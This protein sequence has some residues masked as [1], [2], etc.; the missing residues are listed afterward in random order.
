MSSATIE[1]AADQRHPTRRSSVESLRLPVLMTLPTLV[2]VFVVIGIPL[3]YSLA[4][5]LHRINM[6]TQ[7]WIF[8]GLQN[9]LEI[10]PQPDFLYAM[11]RT[12]YFAVVTVSGGLALG[13]AMALV[14]NQR[15]WGRGVLRSFVLIPWAMSPVAVGILWGW[16]LNGNYGTFNGIL[17]DLGL[18]EKPIAWLA[19]GW[20]ALN[21]VAL[22][23]IWNQA[24]LASL[25]ILAGLQSM[26]ENLHRAARID[27]AG[28]L[29]RFFRITLPWLRPMLLLVL[30]L[31]TINSIMAFDL[32]WTITK[33]GPGSATTVFSWMGYAYAFQ[34]F[35]FGEGAAI[36]YVLTILCLGLAWLYLRLFFPRTRRPPAGS[37]VEAKPRGLGHE[38]V[39]RVESR[40]QAARARLTGRVLGAGWPG[41]RLRRLLFR[42]GLGTGV[43]L[44]FAW[45]AG[46]FLWLVIMSLSPSVDL[47]RTP[48]TVIPE[49]LT[50]ENFRYV[51][52]PGGAVDGQ[53]SVQATRVPL[54]IWNSFVVASFVTAINV[55]IGSLAGY[56]YARHGRGKFMTGSLWALMMTRM[57]PSLALILP[58]F[59]IFRMADL[60]DTRT[61]L[62]IAYCS[63]ILPLSTWIMKGYFE[64]LPPNLERAALVDG[65]TR[66]EAIIKIIL[67]VAKPGLVAAGIF[68]FLVSWNEFIFALILTSTPQ[69]Q[70]I[71][72]II[73]GFL[74]QLRF[75]DYGPMFAASVLAIL[76]PVLLALVFQRHLVSGMLSGSLKG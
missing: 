26:P 34:F 3:V 66:L 70:T 61:A 9:Y 13:M 2:I 50:L 17:T 43:L 4:L 22:V 42:L 53:S 14:L 49:T 75:Y 16:M 57:T 33:G 23:H 29:V 74:V 20:A 7:Q 10:L 5:S 62:V 44:I 41:A 59:I 54:S 21:L 12:L 40:V 45:S 60:I 58:F 24:P 65:C 18:V 8:V 52:F 38:L 39:L 15:F 6:L 48:P 47:V 46:P 11:G 51:L 25:L 55:V 27:G 73:S 69:S 76:P 28:P 68:C 30:I 64:G 32:F 67:P 56:A 31:T 1:K 63:L 71:P 36:L 37:D 35:R 72:V 19:N